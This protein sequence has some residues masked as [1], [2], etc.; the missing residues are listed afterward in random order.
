MKE[1]EQV[2]KNFGL[3]KFA[4]ADEQ[5]EE[6]IEDLGTEPGIFDGAASEENAEYKERLIDYFYG[7]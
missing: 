4:D 2:I 7:K 6:E 3:S 5:D 1:D